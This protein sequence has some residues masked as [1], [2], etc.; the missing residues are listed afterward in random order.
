LKDFMELALLVV[1]FVLLVLVLLVLV[2]LS[3]FLVRLASVVEQIRDQ[4]STSVVPPADRPN[5][6]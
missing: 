5:L 3:S 4:T 2:G 1:I 6:Q